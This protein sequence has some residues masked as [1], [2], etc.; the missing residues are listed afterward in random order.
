MKHEDTVEAFD[1]EEARENLKRRKERTAKEREKLFLKAT[2]D[3]ESIIGMITQRFNP[4]RIYQW[5]S[6]LQKEMFADYS[7]IDIALE[8]MGSIQDVMELERV[9]ES[10]TDFP[11]DIVEIEKIDPAH[12]DSIR[13]K[14]R[15]AYERS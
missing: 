13:S 8:G 9:A 15:L 10:M 2:A 12:A 4:K 3:C 11:L 1:I 7:D 5:G 14:G 6:L